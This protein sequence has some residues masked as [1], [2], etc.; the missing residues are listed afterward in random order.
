MVRHAVAEIHMMKKSAR[1]LTVVFRLGTRHGLS[2][3]MRLA[4]HNE[5]GIPV[6]SVEVLSC[7]ESESEALVAG[8]GGVNLGCRVGPP[9]GGPA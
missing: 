2:P 1:G 9:S 3:G 8:E 6:G 7:Q 4:V 5:D